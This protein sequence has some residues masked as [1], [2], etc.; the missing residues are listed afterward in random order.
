MFR[1]KLRTLLIALALGPLFIWAG[2]LVREALKPVDPQFLYYEP[3]LRYY[4]PGPEFKLERPKRPTDPV[5]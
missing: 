2:W 4:A 3:D 1:Y 5:P